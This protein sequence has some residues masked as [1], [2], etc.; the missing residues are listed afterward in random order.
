MNPNNR[1]DYAP[2]QGAGLRK[3]LLCSAVHAER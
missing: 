3:A 2:F 1:I